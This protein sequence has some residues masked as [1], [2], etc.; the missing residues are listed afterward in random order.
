MKAIVCTKYGPPEVLMLREV[1]KPV[2]GDNEIL[3]RIHATAVS[4]GDIRLRKADPF[5]VRFSLVS[6]N[7]KNQYSGLPWPGKLKL[8]ARM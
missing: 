7:Q 5:A 1:E 8:L 4:S 2:P 3:I 6:Q